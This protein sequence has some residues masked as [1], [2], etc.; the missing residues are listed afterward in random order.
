MTETSKAEPYHFK[1][2]II[3]SNWDFQNTITDVSGFHYVWY[4]ASKD[5][6]ATAIDLSKS[7]R[8]FV[9]SGRQVAKQDEVAENGAD[10]VVINL[11]ELTNVTIE[12][13]KVVAEAAATSEDIVEHLVKHRL[14]LPLSDDPLKSIAS[15]ILNESIS[16]L[17]RS[18][19]PLSDYI[20][21]ID[22][23]KPD[24][25]PITFKD[26]TGVSCLTLCQ[27]SKSIVTE[28]TFAAVPA[29]NLW[30][31]RFSI[32]YPGNDEFLRLAQGLFLG[33]KVPDNC[34][35]VLDFHSGSHL[36]PIVRITAFGVAQKGESEL[37]ELLL[38]VVSNLPAVSSVISNLPAGHAPEI[39]YGSDILKV[40]VDAGQGTSLDP[41]IYSE[42]LFWLESTD[43]NRADFI[44][45]YVNYIHSGASDG[46]NEASK[47]RRDTQ[48]SARL[49]INRNNALEV[50]GYAYAPKK[51]T[52][53][54]PHNLAAVRIDTPLHEGILQAQHLPVPTPS[55]P[56]PNFKGDIFQPGKPG[57]LSRTKVYATSSYPA[58]NFTPLMVAYPRDVED[59]A[60]AIAFARS[61]NLHIVARSGGHQY[62]GKSSG[63]SNTIVLSMDAFD[64]LSISENIVNIGPAV[65][66]TTLADSFNQAEITIPH[67]ECPKVAIGGHAQT[68]GYGHLVRNFG[69]ALDFVEAFNIVLA[70]GRL[71]TVNRPARDSVPSSEEEKLN[72]EIFWGV[73]GGNAGSFGIVTNYT[74][75]CIKDG[76]YK[77]SYG[78]AA[79]RQYKKIRF[80]KLMALVQRLSQG[81]EAGT[82]SE[83]IDLMITV[84][85]TRILFF[86]IILAEVVSKNL[87]V[88]NKEVIKDEILQSIDEAFSSDQSI[89]ELPQYPEY[90]KK[91]LSELSNSF[92]RRFPSTTLDGREFRYP[93]KK[94]INCTAKALTDD[95]IQ[96]FIG[97]ADE[98][99]METEGVKLVFQMLLGGGAYQNTERREATSIPHRDYV[100]CFVFDLF[101]RE[102]FEE[103]AEKLQDRMQAVVD[104]HFSENQ[105]QRVFWGS[106]GDT[107]ISNNEIR[108]MYYDSEERYARLQQLKQALDPND[109]FHTT[110]TVQLP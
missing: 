108:R 89:W 102:G 103:D 101:Y 58:E 92:V 34:D 80:Q 55:E 96:Q 17:T 35:L 99:L 29:Q 106:F 14:V 43:Q 70:D 68:G 75:N 93:Y 47:L 8:T 60:A 40:I 83:D 32:P 36:I 50:T 41:T 27:E 11:S 90:E 42:R 1:G 19:G 64:Q 51:L 31:K 26:S 76:D 91:S 110:L 13:N 5:D 45:Q 63:G 22:A 72:R 6:V 33:S 81:V 79:N 3:P 15:N 16:C 94:R 65:L 67:G 87:L 95:F 97:I 74:F 18:L 73:L 61:K 56:I 25:T 28:I 46:E 39:L 105:E 100:F 44:N 78:Y 7:Q 82:L 109:I 62:S 21:A 98:V 77:N 37:M 104:Q 4:P 53:T 86:P 107:N 9:R 49:Q 59:I 12:G 84:Q 69:L 30:M 2:R 54:T 10:M 38:T 24:G 20:S 57:Y 71:R 52:Y 23:V 66:L 88:E 85:S 48:I